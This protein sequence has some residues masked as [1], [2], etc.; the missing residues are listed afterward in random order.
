MENKQYTYETFGTC[1][2]YIVFE[3]DEAQRLHNVRFIGGCLGN[4][5]GVGALVEGMEA[6]EVCK[7]LAG[8]RC[9]AKPTSCP[10]QLAKAI[11]KYTAQDN[12]C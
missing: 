5:Q 4:T 3:V 2:K 7:R 12:R 8:I 10:D 9:G 6:S 11:E 1:A